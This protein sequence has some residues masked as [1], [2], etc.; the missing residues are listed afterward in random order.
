MKSL[1]LA[2]FLM[3]VAIGNAFVAV[4]NVFIQNPD[5]TSKLAGA[6]YY[7]FFALCMLATAIVFI[8]VAMAYKEKRYLQD[9]GGGAD[10]DEDDG[11]PD[12]PKK[13]SS[14]DTVTILDEG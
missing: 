14:L 4:V 11:P 6:D 10:D 1:V 3:S 12:P 8:P 5:G 13:I 2:L 7:N 9:E